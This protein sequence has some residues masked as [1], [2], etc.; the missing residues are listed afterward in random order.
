MD[1]NAIKFPDVNWIY[2]VL[3]VAQWTLC[4]HGNY[5]AIQ[6][7]EYHSLRG[8]KFSQY[9]YWDATPCRLVNRYQRYGGPC[10][11]IFCLQED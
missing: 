7:R 8:L 2:I 4:K 3:N 6:R 5:A 1:L 10:C 9:C 11:F